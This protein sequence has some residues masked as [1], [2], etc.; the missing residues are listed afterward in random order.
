MARMEDESV[1]MILQDPP[2]GITACK[3]DKPINLEVF[4]PEWKR[5]IKPL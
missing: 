2:Y 5:I 3:W 4:W 1:D